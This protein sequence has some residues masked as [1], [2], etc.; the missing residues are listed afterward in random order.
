MNAPQLLETL[1]ARGARLL[2]DGA[3]LVVKPRDVLTDELRAEIRANKS[4]LL[5][6]LQHGDRFAESSAP[7][8]DAPAAQPPTGSASPF[9]AVAPFLLLPATVETA[10]GAVKIAAT[11][12]SFGRTLAA[13]RGGDLPQQPLG[14]EIG[15]ELFTVEN[16]AAACIEIER[17]WTNTARRC[18]REKRDL[19]APEVDALDGAAQFLE[20]VTACYNGP[21]ETW[22]DLGALNSQLD[23]DF[24][25]M[26]RKQRESEATP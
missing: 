21:G 9:R 14:V 1:T 16:A 11:L 22:L 4:A 3:A 7:A 15:D 8:P 24:R 6:L 25:A 23:A 26:H 5:V 17:A 12:Q 13:A 10:P 2:L 20:T 19:T 18:Q